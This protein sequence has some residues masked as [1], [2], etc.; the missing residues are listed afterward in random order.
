MN[1]DYLK[2]L[3][4]IDTSSVAYSIADKIRGMEDFGHFRSKAFFI[5]Y[6]L[7]QIAENANVDINSKKKFLDCVNVSENIK[8]ILNRNLT[9]EWNVI[10]SLVG[11]YSSEE[12]LSYLLF[13]DDF[14][15]SKGG[16]YSTPE[17]LLKLSCAILNLEEGDEVL[18]LCSGNG[19]FFVE[20]YTE[21]EKIHY[22]GVELNFY[23]NDIAQI[24]ADLIGKDITLV[25][26]DALEYRKEERVNKIFSNYPFAIRSISAAVRENLTKELGTTVETL[27]R[28][29]S[30]W[31][32]NA[33]IIEQMQ[34]SGKAVA[35]MTNGATWNAM[36]KGI[37][38][39]FVENGLIETV[40]SLPEKLFTGFSI[41][42]TL[43]VFN[44]G[45]T[46]IRMVDARSIYT[47]KR[48]KNILSDN[49]VKTILHLMHQSGEKST[50]RSLS[51]I[52]DNEYFL[53]AS[54]YLEVLPE[55]KNGVQLESISKNIIRG[56]QIKAKDLDDLKSNEV[57]NYKFLSLSNI[58]DGILSFD[59][60]RYL[61]EIPS[62]MQ[63][64]CVKNNAIVLTR[65][66]LPE[67][68]TAIVRKDEDTEILATGNFFVIEL[69]ERKVDPFY[70]QAFLASEVGE[71]LL[72]S[73]CSGSNIPMISLD[74][75]NKL[76]IPLPSIKE[77]HQIGNKYAAAMDETILLKRRLEKSIS[78]MKHIYSGEI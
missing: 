23:S 16:Y 66:G 43:V 28:A 59:D 73:I 18:D 42:T 67:F 48:K 13:N 37:R 46:K 3:K 27:Q 38:R 47:K 68:K 58:V 8:K 25:L 22:T 74:K 78:K 49:N 26:N 69:D 17:G 44:K 10:D 55:F 2:R 64:F 5:A 56:A 21:Q 24:R 60:G 65:T 62:N 39:Y 54:R 14:E 50:T 34:E 57:T 6:A 77:Q 51:E 30:D 75:L 53:N 40:I 41:P 29:S 12:L 32:F 52:A 45:N 71:T 11:R 36:D 61:K 9:E 72:K 76:V 33:A 31:L 7:Y 19:N 63:K 15:D 1:R 20:A 4:T 70:L 35:I